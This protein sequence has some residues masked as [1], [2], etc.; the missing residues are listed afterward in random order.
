MNI[1]ER[2]NLSLK[3][4]D[5]SVRGGTDPYLWNVDASQRAPGIPRGFRVAE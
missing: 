5:S 1:R 2:L 4:G 3:V